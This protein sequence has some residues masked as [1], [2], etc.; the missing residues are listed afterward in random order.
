MNVRVS[1][2]AFAICLTALRVGGAPTVAAQSADSLGGIAVDSAGGPVYGALIVAHDAQGKV[3]ARAVSGRR[4]VFMMP[5]PTADSARLVV[6]RVGYPVSRAIMAPSGA[7]PAT[8]SL[9]VPNARLRYSGDRAHQRG[10]CGTPRDSTSDVTVL[11]NAARVVLESSQLRFGREDVARKVSQF[12]RV[13]ARDG[14]VISS[15]IPRERDVTSGPPYTSLSPDSIDAVG[16]VVE[17]RKETSYYAPDANIMLS[18]GFAKRSC[19][20]VV[21]ATA[22]RPDLVGL[23]FKPEANREGIKD[24]GGIF[25]FSRETL[26]LQTLEYRY[27]N[28]PTAFVAA[29]VGGELTF[30]LLPVGAWIISRWE[31]RM[32][33]GE[34]HSQI[35]LQHSIARERRQVIV[36]RVL[37]AIGEVRSV[38]IGADAFTIPSPRP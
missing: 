22:E 11:W 10:V 1:P 16:Y 38:R 12:D 27:T 33:Q 5:M 17:S 25:W 23:S 15:D 3:V 35:A 31:V 9:L 36:E 34:I 37:A 13:L 19:F 21:A 2:L 32:P 20:G 14:K 6:H 18:P 7:R 30:T 28:V 8:F 29:R 26:E 4:G 24:I